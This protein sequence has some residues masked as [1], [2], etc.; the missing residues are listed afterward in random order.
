M[1]KSRSWFWI[2]IM[3]IAAVTTAQAQRRNWTV[4][5]ERVVSD[6]ADHDRVLLDGRETFRALRFEV[7]GHP[8]DFHRVVIHF[9]NGEDQ[10]V[11]LRQTIRAGGFSR[12]ID[13]DGGG[14][15]IRSIDFWYDAKEYAKGSG[16]ASVRTF[17]Q[18]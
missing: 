3:V 13:L 11:E 4:I 10:K 15:A 6:R 12:D 2:A 8:L 17:G 14:R 7:S 9:R 16:R 5:G 18:R 1:T